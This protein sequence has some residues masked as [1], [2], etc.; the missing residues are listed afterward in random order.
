M[1]ILT[2]IVSSLEKCRCDLTPADYPRLERLSALGGERVSFQL[3]LKLWEVKAFGEEFT[4][5]A[6]CD[7]PGLRLR[8]V[9][10]VFLEHDTYLSDP[11]RGTAKFLDHPDRVYPDIL[12]KM[13]KD[14][15]LRTNGR[16]MAVW[17][18]A[19]IPE[20]MEAGEHTVS[21]SIEYGG[22]TVA[23][24]SIV[25][26][27]VGT[28][29]ADPEHICT[30]WFHV[31]CLADYYNV[32][33]YSERHFEII[34]NFMR[35]AF[36]N[37]IN[38]IYV[39]VLTPPLDTKIG[40]YRKTSQLVGITFEDGKYS[41]DFSLLDRYISIAERIGMK[42]FEI[43]HIF[44]Q[45]GAKYAPKVV[46]NVRENGVMTEKRIFGWD[47]PGTEGA[48]PAF[49]G[50]FLPALRAHL[51][52][53]GILQSC[54]FHISD[55]PTLETLE[56]YRAAKETV[57]ELLSGL[58]T[59]DACSH[60]EFFEQG[61]METPV[62]SAEHIRP[63]LGLDIPERWTY[64]CCTNEKDAPNRM[65]CYPS[66]RSRILG[67]LMYKYNIKGFLQ[68][69]FNFYYDKGSVNLINPYTDMSGGGWVNAGD[70]FV[71]YPGNDGTPV[72]SLR[73]AVFAQVFYDLR[74]LKKCEELCGREAV[75]ALVDSE[76]EIDFKDYPTSAEYILTL[77]ER[78]NALIK[79][80]LEK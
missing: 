37:G 29:L 4:V 8:A 79:K 74:A 55:E 34:E 42:Y 2:N 69:A 50:Q 28:S 20:D 24:E 65:I 78:V 56:G 60:T 63:F 3:I 43:S 47:T 46:S 72:E 6:R 15:L 35:A 22:E 71:V 66:F 52:S 17:A 41:F 70:T 5:N 59:V 68:W 45:W 14:N 39:P 36:E 40:H 80:A 61:L 30:N 62:P 12:E 23:R 9:K 21:F 44:S 27:T 18:D 38:T 1:K 73:L 13:P 26:E 76:G 54:I 67:A 7:I 49:L 16:L 11:S 10:N 53:L 77:R 32:P 51:D 57:R 25:I 64:Y 75:M 58:K 48:Y 33:M 19:L 31:D